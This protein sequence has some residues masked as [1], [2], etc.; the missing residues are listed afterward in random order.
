MA[1]KPLFKQLEESTFDQSGGKSFSDRAPSSRPSMKVRA[2]DTEEGKWIKRTNEQL[3]GIYGFSDIDDNKY[4]AA[5]ERVFENA[6]LEEGED[7]DFIRKTV[8]GVD[9]PYLRNTKENRDKVDELRRIINEENARTLRDIRMEAIRQLKEEGR[10]ATKTNIDDKLE[11]MEAYATLESNADF[12]YWREE[13]GDNSLSKY[14]D[15]LRGRKAGTPEF[16]KIVR[17][18]AVEVKKEKEAERKLAQE[19][20]KR[21]KRKL[22]I[23]GMR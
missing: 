22:N 10:K 9:V 13:Q 8:N 19:D 21:A 5:W 7:K 12:I 23:N 14:T 15:A 17:E 4:I 2:G 18:M 1:K 11:E 16:T 6:G 3:K 20:L